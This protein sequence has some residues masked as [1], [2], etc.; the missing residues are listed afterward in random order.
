MSCYGVLKVCIRTRL[1]YRACA[2]RNTFG[3]H[4][5]GVTPL[6]IPNREVKPCSADGTWGASPWESRSP[7]VFFTK[8]PPQ[9]GLSSFLGRV[10]L[11]LRVEAAER[12][13]P[14]LDRW[15]RR[16]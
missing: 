8:G 1:R 6:P 16:E 15:V 14:L 10:E 13:D 2:S 7:P 12:T 3:G 11:E 9:A 4:S 5:A